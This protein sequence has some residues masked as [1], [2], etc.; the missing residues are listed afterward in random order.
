MVYQGQGLI[1]LQAVSASQQ[2]HAANQHL[3]RGLLGLTSNLFFSTSHPIDLSVQPLP[4]T[5]GLCTPGAPSFHKLCRM[6]LQGELLLRRPTNAA[7]SWSVT[8]KLA[9]ACTENLWHSMGGGRTFLLIDVKPACLPQGDAH[10]CGSPLHL[11]S[12]QLRHS[13][14]RG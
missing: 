2:D 12:S 4:F 5:P 9:D 10:R 6:P 3:V 14:S 7:E 1:K 13:H 8:S 11:A